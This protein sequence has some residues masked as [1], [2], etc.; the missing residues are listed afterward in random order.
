MKWNKRRSVSDSVSLFKIPLASARR[1]FS[2]IGVFAK[3]YLVITNKIS[4]LLI[5]FEITSRI[6]LKY[7]SQ[8]KIFE[9]TKI[10]RSLDLG[11]N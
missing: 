3:I 2:E 5:L 9:V 8:Q 10:F 4:N 1:Y 11:L 7:L 6:L